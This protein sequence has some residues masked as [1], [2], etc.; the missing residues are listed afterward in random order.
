MF[1]YLW[2]KEKQI[3]LKE[4]NVLT[5]KAKPA[6]VLKISSG[7]VWGEEP[8]STDSFAEARFAHFPQ[9]NREEKSFCVH[10]G[11]F[12]GTE[13]LNTPEVFQRPQAR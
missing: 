4:K 8:Q 2:S 12:S 7:W 11:K 6:A 13:G 5:K 3:R 9:A 1:N 10:D